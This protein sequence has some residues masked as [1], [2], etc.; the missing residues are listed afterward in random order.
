MA[1]QTAQ[2]S[3]LHSFLGKRSRSGSNEDL[4]EALASDDSASSDD[5]PKAKKK[6]KKFPD[7]RWSRIV[8]PDGDEDPSTH[9][10][11]L[12][13]DFEVLNRLSGPAKRRKEKN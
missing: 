6:K 11:C 12:H 13:G 8:R 4:E 9:E 10:H 3:T 5:G 1:R 2:Q 7:G